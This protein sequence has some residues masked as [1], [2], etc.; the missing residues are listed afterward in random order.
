MR[1]AI[2]VLALGALALVACNPSAGRPATPSPQATAGPQVT[3]TPVAAAPATPQATSTATPR[4]T[5]TALAGQATPAGDPTIVYQRS[6]GIAGRSERWTVDPSGRI[7]GPAGERQ[8]PAERVAT[9]LAEIE[10]AGFFQLGDI[11][12]RG[13]PCRDCFTVE[14]TVRKGDTMK[15][16]TAVLETQDTP[17]ALRDVVGKVD[18]FVRGQ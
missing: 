2:L 4:P 10:A 18:K 15:K 7:V 16:V 12:G 3:A 5:A 14:L 6:G 9:L 8:V 11:Y 17:A 13:S 1:Y